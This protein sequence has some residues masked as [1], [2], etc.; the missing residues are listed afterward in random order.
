MGACAVPRGRKRMWAACGFMSPGARASAPEART[1]S[2]RR[3]DGS[4]AVLPRHL[5]AL[6]QQGGQQDRVPRQIHGAGSPGVGAAQWGHA[7]LA[8]RAKRLNAEGSPPRYTASLGG[9]SASVQAAPR[10][11]PIIAIAGGLASTAAAQ[12]ADKSGEAC[13]EVD[14]SEA[15]SRPGVFSDLA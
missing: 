5:Q 14:R 8:G 12:A 11:S 1:G 4:E 3:Q 15:S 7:P 9:S 13:G 2:R 10:P 6:R